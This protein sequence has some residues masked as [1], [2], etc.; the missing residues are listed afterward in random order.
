MLVLLAISAS[1]RKEFSKAQIPLDNMAFKKFLLINLN[2]MINNDGIIREE[3]IYGLTYTSPGKNSS[4]TTHSLEEII[5]E[6]YR[7]SLVHEGEL[8]NDVFFM[9]TREQ[10]SAFDY[11][12][13]FF[14]VAYDDSQAVMSVTFDNK[15][16]MN[17]EWL[18]MLIKLVEQADV[19]S[20]LFGPRPT[21]WN[22]NKPRPINFS[23][24]ISKE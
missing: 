6:Q 14:L 15:L 4:R 19:N 1:S 3:P 11:R 23:V 17:Y 16:I 18:E 12:E 7:C 24:K 21:N 13:H 5:Y 22:L 2:Q 8:P 9:I 10:D 20:D